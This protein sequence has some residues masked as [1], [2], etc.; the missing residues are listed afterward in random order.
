MLTK[1]Y[2]FPDDGVQTAVGAD[3]FAVLVDQDRRR[4]GAIAST[5]PKVGRRAV[6]CRFIVY[7]LH[8]AKAFLRNSLMYSRAIWV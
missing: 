1:F 7:T 3:D 2:D 8:F 4:V 5:F 6:T